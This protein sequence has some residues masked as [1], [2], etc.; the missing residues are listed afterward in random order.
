VLAIGA[1]LMGSAVIVVL[2]L[3]QVC[4]SDARVLAPA[5]QDRPPPAPLPAGPLTADAL[6]AAVA[7]LPRTTRGCS[8]EA[9]AQLLGEVATRR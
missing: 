9:V 1:V 6:A 3:R 5:Q 7:A 4:R 8:P 2:V